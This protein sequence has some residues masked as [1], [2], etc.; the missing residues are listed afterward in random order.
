MQ[1]ITTTQLRTNTQQLTQAL[2]SGDTIKLIHRSRI[3]GSITPP[4]TI[5]SSTKTKITFSQAVKNAQ[6]EFSKSGK[7]LPQNN[8]GLMKAYY[9]QLLKKHKG[10]GK[11]LS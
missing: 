6:K 5:D 8:E 4:D 2:E 7:K 1:L 3:I 9:N 10:Y 11:N